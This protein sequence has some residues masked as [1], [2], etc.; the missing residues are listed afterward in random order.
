MRKCTHLGQINGA[1]TPSV[2]GCEDCLRIGGWWVHLRVPDLRP[3]R[4]L[5]FEPQSSRH[6]ALPR[7]GASDRPLFRA[8]RG[9]A[10]VLRGRG[11][12]SQNTKQL[13]LRFRALLNED[14]TRHIDLAR[15]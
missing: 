1:V 7:D 4:L 12:K 2:Q 9:V 13:E 10:L 11:C 3:R 15:A 6:Q 5:R 8:G 14:G